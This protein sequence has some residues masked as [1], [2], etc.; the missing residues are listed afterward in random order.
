MNTLKLNRRRLLYLF[1]AATFSLLPFLGL[2]RTSADMKSLLELGWLTLFMVGALA[3]VLWMYFILAK[4]IL[5]YRIFFTGRAIKENQNKRIY[6]S[7]P[8]RVLYSDILSVQYK[9]PEIIVVRSKNEEDFSFALGDIEGGADVVLETLKSHLPAG[10]VGENLS[11]VVEKNIVLSRI[12]NFGGL[13]LY[14]AILIPIVYG[15][16]LPFKGGWDNYHTPWSESILYF[17][18]TPQ[19]MPWI[20]STDF[21]DENLLIRFDEQEWVWP[22]PQ[23]DDGEKEVSWEIAL[24]DPQGQPTLI[25]REVSTTWQNGTWTQWKYYGTYSFIILPNFF[26]S[27]DEQAWLIL[28]GD[29]DYHDL[30][31]ATA[32]KTGVDVIKLPEFAE[33]RKYQPVSL[34]MLPDETVLVL[35]GNEEEAEVFLLKDGVWLEKSYHV[36]FSN[37]HEVRDF[38]LD[39]S[40][41]LYFIFDEDPDSKRFTVEMV[42]GGK[43]T[44]TYFDSDFRPSYLLVDSNN[45]VWVFLRGHDGGVVVLQPVWGGEAELVVSYNKDNSNFPSRL[46]SAPEISADGK[47]WVLGEQLLWLDGSAHELPAPPPA[48]LVDFSD[49][50]SMKRIYY[51]IWVAL[52]YFA[53]FSVLKLISSRISK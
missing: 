50:G 53:G 19:S 25:G 24:S 35:A 44:T 33:Q 47:I 1:F 36:P 21:N 40:G 38:I 16:L 12:A 34:S 41:R 37:V 26:V 4:R 6:L 23:P 51:F 5:N 46:H 13:L 42:D 29:N 27:T 8:R 48:W 11:A 39:A 45:R 7:G 3:F 32:G 30:V 2:L 20:V 22:R 43:V 17:S 49:P 10:L 9:F 15:H 52:V 18:V 14:G 28:S 31:V